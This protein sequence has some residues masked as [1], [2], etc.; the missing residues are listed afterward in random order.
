VG[1]VERG[2]MLDASTAK[3]QDLTAG[4]F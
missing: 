3:P 4:G 2:E 1:L